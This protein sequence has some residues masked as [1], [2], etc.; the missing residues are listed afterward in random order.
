MNKV[1][2]LRV[3]KGLTIKELSEMVSCGSGTIHRIE[4][5][6]R[7]PN[8]YLALKIAKAFGVQVEDVF[9]E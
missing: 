3:K 6:D 8:V 2:E 1:K 9:S 5:D 7:K 4:S